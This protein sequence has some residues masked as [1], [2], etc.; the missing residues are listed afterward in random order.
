MKYQVFSCEVLFREL[1]KVAADSPPILDL[2]FFPLGL[3]STPEKLREELQAAIDAEDGKH[4]AVLLGYGLC[5]RGTAGLIARRVPIVIPRAHDCITLLLGSK[6]RYAEEFSANPGTYYYSSGWVERSEGMV[7]QSTTWSKDVAREQR[8]AEYVEKFGEDNARYLIEVEAGWLQHYKRAAFIETGV[9][10]S[11]RYR[12]FTR[13]IAESHGWEYRELAGSLRL[14]EGL[15]SGNWDPA[16][17]L[18][19]PP[20][21]MV[22]DTV[23]G[24]II[25]A[26]RQS[27]AEPN[28]PACE[29]SCGRA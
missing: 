2:V 25:A 13:S 19:V 27:A 7:D 11:E 22:T 12:S 28:A 24:R 1:C 17:F 10:D 18:V 9:G 21:C 29:N 5:S 16:E 20:G 4:D 8:Y 26:R 23:D 6:E 14:L 15:V 3:H